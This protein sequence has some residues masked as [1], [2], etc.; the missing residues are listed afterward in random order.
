MSAKPIAQFV[1]ELIRNSGGLLSRVSAPT[2]GFRGRKEEVDAV[3][4]C[5]MKKRMRNCIIVGDAGVGKSEIAKAAIR[6]F[7][8]E[9]GTFLNFDIGF[10]Q[11]GCTLIGQFEER[12]K[13]VFSSICAFNR[14]SDEKVFVFIDEIHNLWRVNKNEYL[15]TICAGDMLKPFLADGEL[16]IVGTTTNDEYRAYVASDKALLRRLPPIFVTALEDDTVRK[17]VAEFAGKS[18]SPEM[19]EAILKASGKVPYLHNPDCALEIA[20]RVMARALLR[21]KVADAEDLES[22]VRLMGAMTA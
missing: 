22:V 13:N 21:Q 3:L 14:A 9:E 1:S 6:R 18:L 7:G 19:V 5:L 10:V 2:K 16:A 4:E 15:G 20:D 8:R 17:I 11:S 12:M